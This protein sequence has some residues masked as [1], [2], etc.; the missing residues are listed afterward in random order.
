MFSRISER[1]ITQ[2][3]NIEVKFFP[4][5]IMQN[6]EEYPKL[7]LKKSLDSTNCISELTACWMNH[8]ERYGTLS[9]KQIIKRVYIT[10]K[11]LSLLLLQE[12]I[13]EKHS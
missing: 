1:K 13:T 12:L 7:L 6:M 4:R 9:F 3:N 11:L 8:Q 2:K 5:G 10:V